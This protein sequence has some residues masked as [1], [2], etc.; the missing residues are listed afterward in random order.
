MELNPQRSRYLD[1]N[2]RLIRFGL[3]RSGTPSSA[4]PFAAWTMST[5]AA[6]P[7]KPVS[8]YPWLES[9]LLSFAHMWTTP[10][11][12][13]S[14]ANKF[15]QAEGVF[16]NDRKGAKRCTSSASTPS[17]CSSFRSIEGHHA[18]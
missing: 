8:E 15:A 9:L 14:A 16:R 11:M 4:K 5:I 17:P 6:R 2:V 12:R 10:Q 7:P 13:S 1:A 18:L 3:R